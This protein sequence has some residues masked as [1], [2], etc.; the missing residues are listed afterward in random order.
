M[1]VSAAFA[2]AGCSGCQEDVL[3][4]A[5]EWLRDDPQRPG[6]VGT[7]RAL[8]VRQKA[9]SVA[10]AGRREMKG[11]CD[12][13]W[14][15]EEPF[16]VAFTLDI[17]VEG[18]DGEQQWYEEGRWRRGAQGRW[19]IEV[20][21]EFREGDELEGQRK[22]KVFSDDD[23]FW[24]WLGPEVAISHDSK[25]QAER[26][27]KK[28]FGSRFSALASLYS[29]GWE[30]VD[31][32]EDKTEIWRPGDE[33][34]WCGPV[35]VSDNGEAWSA[36]FDART[37]S[38]DVEIALEWRSP[39]GETEQRCRQ[40]RAEHELGRDERMEVVFR[41]CHRPGPQ[42]LELPEVGRVVDAKRD[43]QRAHLQKV[44][45]DWLEDGMAQPV[46]KVR[47]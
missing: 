8:Q 35:E 30:R 31:K 32:R 25:S 1:L 26:F 7:L 21:A 19:G 4:R 43:R 34:Y 40:I 47:D 3:D 11:P 18:R 16:S 36:L 15:M 44:L 41:E 10:E 23:G 28:E 27:W 13:G 38:T 20:E 46:E 12:I 14:D 45:K 39:A 22:K 33:A 37:D 17:E 9:G 2:S 29:S 6:K 24:E 42:R 5:E